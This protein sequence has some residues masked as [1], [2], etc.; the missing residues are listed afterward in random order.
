MELPESVYPCSVCGKIYNHEILKRC[1][2][3]AGAA[4]EDT[5]KRRS[6]STLTS[7]EA[8]S[9]NSTRLDDSRIIELLQTLVNETHQNRIAI[10]R[11]TYVI[12]AVVS[13]IAIVAITSTLAAIVYSVGTSWTVASG[14]SDGFLWTWGLTG[15]IGLIGLISAQVQF[16]RQWG[17]SRVTS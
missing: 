3:C 5:S 11:T 15:L 1:P 16:F 8:G 10:N 2:G 14:N 6:K 13:Y 12:R 9:S 4:A 7:L 17:L